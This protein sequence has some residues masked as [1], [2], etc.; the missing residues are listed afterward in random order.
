MC[1]ARGR[2]TD[3][4]GIE[5]MGFRVR[6]HDMEIM[7]RKEG[8]WRPSESDSVEECFLA[9]NRLVTRTGPGIVYHRVRDNDN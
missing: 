8:I 2:S 1:G 7:R 6:E 5:D 4:Y 9:N 3:T